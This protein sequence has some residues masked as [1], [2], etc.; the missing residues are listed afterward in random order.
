MNDHA[1]DLGR[2]LRQQYEL[3]TEISGAKLLELNT[4]WS[5]WG[6]RRLHKSI[7]FQCL[8]PV[9]RRRPTKR[10]LI[11]FLVLMQLKSYERCLQLGRTSMSLWGYA[12][13]VARISLVYR[14]VE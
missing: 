14:S 6:L 7:V 2:D 12:A 8:W 10:I 9:I 4:G 11:A 13:R 1:T 3:R 5:P